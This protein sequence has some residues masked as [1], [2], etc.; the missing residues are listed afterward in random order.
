MDPFGPLALVDTW[1][2]NCRG[3]DVYEQA[4]LPLEEDDAIRRRF[5][6]TEII[7]VGHILRP[8]WAL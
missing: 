4:I 1:P 8:P 5:F 6:F 7:E 2:T 3:R